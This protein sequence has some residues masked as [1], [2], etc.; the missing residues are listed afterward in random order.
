[1]PSSPRTILLSLPTG[2]NV[3]N[4]LETDVFETLQRGLRGCLVVM[5]PR[6]A[7]VE[8]P[9][10]DGPDMVL[11]P[12]G[13]YEPH[14]I[15][16]TID[17]VISEQFLQQTRLKAVLL[18]RNRARML[19][20]KRT[21]AFWFAAK[22]VVARLPIS[23]ATWYTIC[24][25]LDPN[26]R[27][28]AIFAKY[29]PDLLVTSTAGFLTPELPLIFEAKRRGIPMA[30][31]D[32]GWDNLSS[33]YHT[34]FPV[35]HL[36]VWNERMREEAVQFHGFHP[37]RVQ[38]TGVPQFDAYFNQQGL[39]H[40]E[41]FMAA[42]GADR[43][44]RLITLATTA[45]GTYTAT[46]SIV[47]MLSQATENGAFGEP[48]QVLVRLH[49]RDT[50]EAYKDVSHLPGIVLDRCVQ[51]VEAAIGP[52]SFDELVPTH[53]ER[54]HLAATLAYSDVL[55]NFASTTTIEACIFDTPVIN[56]GFDAAENT[57]LP[58]S[59]RRYFEYE[60]YQ[61]VLRSA[62]VRIATSPGD[63]L[64]Q[65]RQYL[66]EPGLDHDGRMQL[67]SQTCQFTDGKSGTRVGRAVLDLIAACSR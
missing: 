40:R 32:L 19:R 14:W 35:D 33:K 52:V 65:I 1:L 37:R 44:K 61:P 56:I 28:Q 55:I 30:A 4:I 54:A 50:L 31:I 39:P 58:L 24:T 45:A 18:Q 10:R 20:E 48:A 3:A 17:S 38:T 25:R 66:Q 2:H 5:A 59:I 46:A 22:S 51:R 41:E 57:P 62:A 12:L 26:R 63:L 60:H 8:L 21:P 42:V 47:A 49:P 9:R 15:S 7:R 29:Q 53:S 67:V 34:I 11:E 64:A 36:L 16:R 43:T 23:R 6:R 27:Y 13:H